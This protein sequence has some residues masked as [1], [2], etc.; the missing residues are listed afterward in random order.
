LP[1][2]DVIDSGLYTRNWILDR[3]TVALGGLAA[4]AEIFGDLEV[5]TGAGSDIKQVTNLARQMVTLY[6][7]SALGPV[8]L[9]SMGSEVF[10]GRNLMPRSEYSE[11][12]ATKIDEQVRE[13]ATH[14]YNR[15]RQILRDNRALIDYLVD[16]L[17]EQETM[18]GEHFRQI[19]QEYTP[20]P[21]KKQLEKSPV[22]P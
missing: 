3:I 21:E 10:L 17:L 16:R 6:G 5:T 19:V 4:E 18:D 1:N 20:I 7:M 15:A 9:E 11:A 22:A 12:M 14:C 2:E 13:I 8:A